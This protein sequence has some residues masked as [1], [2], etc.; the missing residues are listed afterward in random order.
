MSGIGE[1]QLPIPLDANVSSFWDR[2]TTLN[3]RSK[4]EL[5]IADDDADFRASAARHFRRR[6]FHVQEAA[7]G[8]EA[9]ELLNKRNFDVA[10]L[11]MMM[12]GL[13][14]LEVL[15]RIAAESRDVE[16]ILLTAQGTIDSAVKAMKLGASDYRT[17]PFSLTELEVLI[18][19]AWERSRLKKENRQLKAVFQ[20]S[21][22]DP[23]IIGQSPRDACGLSADRKSRAKRSAHP[24]SG[25]ERDRQ[26]VGGPRP[27]SPQPARRASPGDFQLR[28][29][30][31]TAFGE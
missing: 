6:G 31:R 17:K 23:E 10:L 18:E 16:V 28:R 8:D 5:L 1:H 22:S 21:Q 13:S 4:I 3:E 27:A 7:S 30:A 19:K 24:H 2:G 25:R 26:G 29:A 14:G 9:L 11:D 15:D 20:R 12:P